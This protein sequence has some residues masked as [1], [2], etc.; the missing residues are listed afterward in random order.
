MK[1]TTTTEQ[2]LLHNH[3]PEPLA[4]ADHPI[5]PRWVRLYLYTAHHSCLSLVGCMPS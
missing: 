2:S 1:K 4:G 3:M 5:P